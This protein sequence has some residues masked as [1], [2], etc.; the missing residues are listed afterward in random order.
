MKT[1]ILF[2]VFI[3]TLVLSHNAFAQ[4]ENV[5]PSV[6]T[7][8]DSH[9][10]LRVRP[11]ALCYGI[12]GGEA[13]YETDG[14]YFIGLTGQSF[15]VSNPDKQTTLNNA[16][17]GIKFGKFF[18]RDS[19]RAYGF[20]I[21]GAANLNHTVLTS[22]YANTQQNLKAQFYQVSGVL[23]AGYQFRAAF[24]DERRLNIR[25]G[26]G[27]GYKPASTIPIAALDG[28][29]VPIGVRKRLDPSLEFTIGYLL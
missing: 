18:G 28:T 23:Y 4:G 17:F 16:E 9:F 25:L 11:L 3:L 2:R 21:Q 19:G 20:F 12:F 27:V 15:A 1:I 7:A 6:E 29:A 8:N 10:S 13:Y 26:V 24:I 5:Q 22:Y 14:G